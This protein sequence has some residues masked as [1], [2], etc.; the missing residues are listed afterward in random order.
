MLQVLLQVALIRKCLGQVLAQLALVDVDDQLGHDGVGVG[1]DVLDEGVA[2]FA[3]RRNV[4]E[5]V[6]SKEGALNIRVVL[7]EATPILLNCSYM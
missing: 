5:D 2:D 4:E 6:A 7:V 1:R 3:E